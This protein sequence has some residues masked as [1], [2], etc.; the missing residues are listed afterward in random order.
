MWSVDPESIT[1]NDGESVSKLCAYSTQTFIQE[2][3]FHTLS[4]FGW[5]HSRTKWTFALQISHIIPS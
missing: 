1:H 5:A 3:E 2:V 4:F